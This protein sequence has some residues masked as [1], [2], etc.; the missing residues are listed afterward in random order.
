MAVSKASPTIAPL[1]TVSGSP[2]SESENF[3][4]HEQDIYNLKRE[5]KSSQRS[6]LEVD[7]DSYVGF[8]Q[9]APLLDLICFFARCKCFKPQTSPSLRPRGNTMQLKKKQE[10]HEKLK[11]QKWFGLFTDL[12]FVAVI[13]QFAFQMKFHLKGFYALPSSP[14]GYLL[15]KEYLPNHD[16]ECEKLALGISSSEVIVNSDG[17]ECVYSG[18]EKIPQLIAETATFWFGFFVA[19][20]EL[21]CGLTRF[22][23]ITGILDDILYAL[24]LMTVVG[25]SVQIY[26]WKMMMEYGSHFSTWLSFAILTQLLIH[27]LYYYVIPECRNYA[28]RRIY[29]YAAA[30]IVNSVGTFFSDW[31]NYGT[32][33]IACGI[34]FYVSLTSFVP[35][36]QTDLTVEH[37]VERFGLL[38][39][40]ATGQSILALLIGNMESDD[41]YNQEVGEHIVIFLAFTIM[42]ILKDLYLNSDAPVQ[43]HALNKRALPNPCIWVFLHFPLSYCILTVGV[44][45]MLVMSELDGETHRYGLIVC[46]PLFL[47]MLIIDLL[48]ATHTDFRWSIQ[49]IIFRIINLVAI[50]LGVLIFENHKLLLLWCTVWTSMQ[51]FRDWF[52]KENYIDGNTSVLVEPEDKVEAKI[53]WVKMGFMGPKV[54]LWPPYLLVDW[55]NNKSGASRV[56]DVYGDLDCHPNEHSRSARE[57][58]SSKRDWLMEFVDLIFV[59]VIWKFADQMKFTLK[60]YDRFDTLWVVLESTLFFSAF[61]CIWLELMTEFVRFRNM[62]GIIDDVVRFCYLF[63]IVM[64]AIQMEN[65][66]YLTNNFVGF[67]F[68]FDC[69]LSAILILHF[70]YL[71]YGVNDAIRYCKWRVGIYTLVI[72]STFI[73][74]QVNQYYLNLFILLINVITLLSYS[75][76]SFRVTESHK[77]RH[78]R[79]KELQRLAEEEDKEL[80]EPIEDHILERFGLFV[81]ITMGESL[82]A[83]VIA[84]AYYDQEALTYT[85]IYVAFYMIFF[86]KIMYSMHNPELEDG[87]ALFEESCPGSVAYCAIHLVLCLSL[88]WMGVSWK[89]IFYK[90]DGS[91]T[92]LL[93]WRMIFGISVTLVMVSLVINRFTHSKFKPDYL[94]WVRIVPI[95]AV[96]GLCY[97]FPKPEYFSIG[98]VCCFAGLYLMDY[99]FY[100]NNERNVNCSHGSD[101][102]ESG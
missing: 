18:P 29:S 19:W 101:S 65:N 82:L 64:M 92:I 21:S 72:V 39:M 36:K 52:W 1:E 71:Y 87:H 53:E 25:M 46:A 27:I 56:K 60:N 73:S 84:F 95:F 10:Q 32:I 2:I 76:N 62:P 98:C 83:L 42:Y 9:E 85:L 33:I 70:Y 4:A 81:M 30:I 37:F 48:R 45:F 5:R 34:I 89:L 50:P 35:Q 26:P 90:W 54:E 58:N 59:G 44:G 8:R 78:L 97:N 13:I 15:S 88:L 11:E 68:A 40:I 96:L 51:L 55:W 41:A 77:D 49:S 16:D 47:C 20:L 17:S 91:G 74:I 94:S 79:R 63:G 22:I 100:N 75:I 12:I 69:S 80:D 93:R 28:W 57:E 66:Q 23:N 24:Y 6:L 67:L 99:R 61:F 3:G 43:L 102:S 14:S 31:V 38:I 7:P 86:I